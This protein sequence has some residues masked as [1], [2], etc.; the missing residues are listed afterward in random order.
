MTYIGSFQTKKKTKQGK[1]TAEKLIERG[2]QSVLDQPNRRAG[3]CERLWGERGKKI[4][5]AKRQLDI[6]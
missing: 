3:M 2:S 5:L 1:M 6:K 4:L